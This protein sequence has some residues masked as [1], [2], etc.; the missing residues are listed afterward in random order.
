[1]ALPGLNGTPLNKAPSE[2][3]PDDSS[4]GSASSQA[5]PLL[6]AGLVGGLY[7]FIVATFGWWN[8]N[9]TSRM[10]PFGDDVAEKAKLVFKNNTGAA[11]LGLGYIRINLAC[12]RSQ[13]MEAMERAKIEL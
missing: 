6:I 9:V 5:K 2:T 7:D 4:S 3:V 1:M 10:L 13:L 11:V 12:P 8:E